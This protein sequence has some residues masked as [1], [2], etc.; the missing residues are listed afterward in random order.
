VL[1]GYR[2]GANS[3]ITKPADFDSFSEAMRTLGWYWLEWNQVP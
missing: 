1:E 2:S 3:Y